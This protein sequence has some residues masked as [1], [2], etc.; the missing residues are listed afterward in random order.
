MLWEVDI[1]AAQGLPDVAGSET[2]T[3]AADLGFSSSLTIG[4]ARGYLVQGDLTREQIDLIVG[5]LLAD[6]VVER[7]NVGLV[8]DP[9]LEKSLAGA[10]GEI[11]YVL[12]KPGVTD[13]V[14]DAARKSAAEYNVAPEA[15]RT[16]KK[17]WISG[18]D[19][20]ELKRLSRKLLSNDAIEQVAYG[21]LGFDSLQVGSSYQFELKVVPI[22]NMSDDDLIRLS[23]EGQLYLSLVEMQTI[24]MHF[25]SLDRDPTDVELE[26]IAQTWS[27]HCSHKT[28]AGVVEYSDGIGEKRLFNNMLKETIFDSTVK[29]REKLGENDFCVSVFSDN[30]GVV[31]FDDEYNVCFKVETH[32]HPS[33][34]EPYGGA[35]TGIG[36]VIRDPMGTGMGAKPVCNTDVFCFAPPQLDSEEVPNGVLHPRRVADGR[37]HADRRI[38]RVEGRERAERVAADVASDGGL[39]LRKDVEDPPVA[40]AGAKDGRAR[41]KRLRRGRGLDGRLDV[42]EELVAEIL[43]AV[44]VELEHVKLRLVVLD[45]DPHRADLLFEEGIELFHDDEALHL[46]R[47]VGDELLRERI[48]PA[49]LED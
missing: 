47:E 8:G 29:I 11:V 28:L 27:E 45:L 6:P 17:Y 35:N 42:A 44:G 20:V 49:E 48:R 9:E 43:Q 16:F 30:A 24:Q 4:T 5:K 19:D 2:K 7:A 46:R 12:P 15:V 14:A 10:L 32:N 37:S 1:F 34:L 39:E 26:T 36:G 33:A 41:G 31:K 40:A 25:V 38:H 18:V 3:D 13:V 23:K 21:R 22:R